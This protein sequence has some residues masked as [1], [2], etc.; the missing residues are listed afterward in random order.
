MIG[1]RI[2]VVGGGPIGLLT[3]ILLMEKGYDVELYE[4]HKDIGEPQHCSGIVSHETL[5]LYP[6]DFDDL[7]VRKLY[8]I[9]LKVGEFYEN[10]FIASVSKAVVLNRKH[11]EE[12]LYTKFLDMG[13]KVYLNRKI[14]TR[15]LGGNS[16]II[17]AGGVNELLK[18]GYKD[19]LP[20]MQYDYFAECEYIDMYTVG[21]YVD[22]EI[23][24]DYFNWIIPV[25]DNTYKI[26]TASKNNLTYVLNRLEKTFEV[27]DRT[28]VK[29][30]YGHI[31]TGG[32]RKTF[33]DRNMIYIGDSA[34]MVKIST[35]GGL[36]YGACGSHILVQ[37]LYEKNNLKKYRKEWMR[38]FGLELRAQKFARNLFLTVDDKKLA[39]IINILS[40]KEIFNL[41]LVE[42][43][44]DF[45]STDLI[46]MLYDR[47]LIKFL[48]KEIGIKYL[49]NW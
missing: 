23:N 43:N 8:G 31:I 32:P 26:G 45:H 17:N 18:S 4:E 28:S 11:V 2:K 5:K 6:I 36:N 37:C 20:A 13:G 44:M 34:G 30:Y 41:L 14:D 46:K 27:R 47:D 29:K 38:K 3:G 49:F 39:E 21:I 16:L 40:K 42:G 7:I 48:I 33:Y 19:V 9:K 15:K 22:K 1:H 12:K 24:P 35:G 10:E 25:R